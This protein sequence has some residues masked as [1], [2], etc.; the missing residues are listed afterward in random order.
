MT[1]TNTDGRSATKLHLLLA[2]ALGLNAVLAGLLIVRWQA[3]RHSVSRR[4]SPPASMPARMNM[5][6]PASAAAASGNLLAPARSP[7][8]D[9][10]ATPFAPMRISAQRLQRIGVTIGRVGWRDL[11]ERIRAPG[12]VSVDE[13]KQSVIQLRFSGWV[14]KTF[15]NRRYQYVRRGQPLL[16]I[17]SPQ[18]L[19][20][21]REYLLAQKNA[22]ALAASPVAGVASGARA[23]LSAAR[24]RLRLWQ[25]PE[26]ELAR[27][28]RTQQAGQYLTLFSPVSGYIV[29]RKV[30]PNQYVRPS[31]RLYSV[32]ALNPVWVYAQVFQNQIGMLRR[33]DPAVVTV[34]AYPGRRW[35]GRINAIWPRVD[36]AT[37]TVKVRLALSNPHL[38]LLP[39]MFVNVSL[40]R[41]LG[42]QLAVPASAILQTG[43]RALAFLYRPGGQ[44]VPRAVSLGPQ[45]HGYFVIR[46]GLRA[47]QRVV[48]SANFLIASESQLQA[49]LGSFAPPPPGAG[50]GT[51]LAAAAADHLQL[52][53]RPS[54][55]R[56]GVN[57]IRVQLTTPQG[58]AVAG[59]CVQVTFFMA[60]MPAM[61][62]AAMRVSTVLSR[63]PGGVYTGSLRLPT[64]GIWQ[65][66]AVASQDGHTLAE[67]QT[68][69]T[70]G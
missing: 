2:L 19:A 10:S 57:Q 1:Q 31:T 20:T 50:Q 43:R 6:Q 3:G 12:N 67:L 4:N 62:M 54:P 35:P 24:E 65:V 59:A 55:P 61:G 27:L 38:R 68:Q 48:T 37:R 7:A 16:T 26:A 15:V 28:N 5:P 44:I 52:S 51:E 40:R 63:G 69:V 47:N 29:R 34:D 11:V 36:P 60:A 46:R 49:A 42:R 9:L 58:T 53:T 8:S 23:L 56:V 64:P 14:R 66:T 39:G 33:G 30:L 25:V 18:L 22:G 17:Y 13:R 45:V 32:A 21:E 41:P 70:T